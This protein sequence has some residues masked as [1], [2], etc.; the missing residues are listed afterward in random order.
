MGPPIRWR[1]QTQ[2]GAGGAARPVADRD[3]EKVLDLVHFLVGEADA[4]PESAA[5]LSRHVRCHR[6]LAFAA[7]GSLRPTSAG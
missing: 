6:L 1:T 4:G 5:F 3:R 2:T 7:L